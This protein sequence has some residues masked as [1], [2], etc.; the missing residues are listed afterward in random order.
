MPQR[1]TQRSIRP[2]P[3]V[4]DHSAL[5]RKLWITC[6]VLLAVF[7]V[8]GTIGALAPGKGQ[9]P[10]KVGAAF[11]VLLF[12]L[13]LWL[14]WYG[15]SIPLDAEDVARR[16][17]RHQRHA[18]ADLRNTP[19]ARLR[20]LVRWLLTPA[21]AVGAAITIVL[22]VLLPQVAKIAPVMVFAGVAAQ[23]SRPTSGADDSR[24]SP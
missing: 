11:G 18:E 20:A 14:L 12:L 10:S 15:L 3:N 8:L 13:A 1:G 17:A 22:A 24:T 23:A 4:S 9:H 7:A 6:G 2:R 5:R 21:G 16:E 19:G